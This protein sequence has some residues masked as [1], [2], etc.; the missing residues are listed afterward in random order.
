MMENPLEYPPDNR[1]LE[2]FERHYRLQQHH[3]A[4]ERLIKVA[5]AFSRLPYENL[6]KIIRLAEEGTPQRARR[7]PR[8]VLAEHFR[9]GTGGTCFSLTAAL[10]YLVRSLGFEGR[11]ILAD[12][13]Y[14]P[15]TH[16]ALIIDFLGSWKL[17]DPGY[18]L[19][20]PVELPRDY[21]LEIETPFNR[22]VL[23]PR[24]QGRRVDLFV[25]ANG[26]RSYRLTFKVEPVDDGQFL[27]AWD[28][29]FF[30]EMMSYPVVSRV[31]G[32]RQ[33]YLQGNR[34]QVRDQKGAERRELDPA[35]LALHLYQHFGICPELAARALEIIKKGGN[36]HGPA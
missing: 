26:R 7:V 13:R 29:S 22:L 3:P 2:E 32:G 4:E 5:G 25:L 30:W 18:L 8:Q 9:L 1:L 21:P 14:G 35:R 11:P 12:R 15:D 36:L 27:R 6:S 19:D 28:N 34:W 17:L 10:L 33:L 31:A 23:A 24:G 20:R 16:C